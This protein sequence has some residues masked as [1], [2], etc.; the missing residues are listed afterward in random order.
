METHSQVQC[1]KDRV[2]RTLPY[3]ECMVQSVVTEFECREVNKRIYKHMTTKQLPKI[4]RFIMSTN[5]YIEICNG[6]LEE[7]LVKIL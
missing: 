4:N 6:S 2:L 7:I 1:S 3:S 5:I